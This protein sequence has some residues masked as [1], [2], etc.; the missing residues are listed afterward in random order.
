MTWEEYGE[1]KSQISPHDHTTPTQLSLPLA[2][3][4]RHA[5]S[6]QQ[7]IPLSYGTAR[8]P[9]S[10]LH[11]APSRAPSC[12]HTILHQKQ[13][14]QC[15]LNVSKLVY[16]KFVV[17]GVCARQAERRRDTPA[18]CTSHKLP[19]LSFPAASL[20]MLAAPTPRPTTLQRPTTFTE[21]G[22]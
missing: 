10:C 1:V 5:R 9:A 19:A 15:H 2:P 17:L 14:L 3:E 4:P 20:A 7:L 16:C 13:S 21:R 8:H 22:T 18:S 12:P 6:R 11:A